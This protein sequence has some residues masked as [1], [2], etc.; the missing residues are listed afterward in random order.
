MIEGSGLSEELRRRIDRGDF[1]FDRW[2]DRLEARSTSRLLTPRWFP[3]IP[4]P[5]CVRMIRS[6]AR[7]KIALAGR[8]SGK[9]EWWMR[10][11]VIDAM[12][13]NKVANRNFAIM[14]PTRDQ[15]KRIFWKH[16]KALA[17][18][19][20]LAKPPLETELTLQFVTGTTLMLVGMD[21]PQ[22]LEGIDIQRA[23]LDE[24]ADW[25]EGAW[26][27]SVEPTLRTPGREGRA[28]FIGRPRS[29]NHFWRLIQE[30]GLNQERSEW[31][32]FHWRSSDIMAESEILD[33]KATSDPRSYARNYDALFQDDAG[34]AYY[35]FDRIRHA[36]EPV[37]YDPNRPLILCF[38][39]NRKP[40]V[41]AYVQEYSYT[42]PRSNVAREFTG[43]FGEVW[44]SDDSTS[45]KVARRVALDFSPDGRYG[46]H[47]S[48]VYL[49]GDAT[50]GAKG[51]AKVAG[52]DWDI[53]LSVLRGHFP[54]VYR[55]FPRAN[56]QELVRINAMNTRLLK[57]DG[58]V[59]LL[60]DPVGC[61]HV[62]QDLEEV[63]WDSTGTELLKEQGGPLTHI[64]DA[65]GYYI[66]RKWPIVPVSAGV[67]SV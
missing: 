55:R 33:A 5:E 12:T 19:A 66:A 10:D 64:S 29:R 24:Y 58:T 1:R 57:A 67:I 27:D 35:C 11:F 20:S 37:K 49:E 30:F 50:G 59:S 2:K 7:F 31:D 39:F 52:S 36:V 21:K 15:V 54:E 56:P 60:I 61:P 45:E 65:I 8:R 34:R 25:K 23:L 38:D 40:G 44:I 17:P 47:N 48:K 32:F 6:P 43:V 26:E 51:S 9:T 13:P 14:A 41:C 46:K 42:G 18:R 22:R 63:T 3:L 16:L 53:I 4:H 62:V 28:A